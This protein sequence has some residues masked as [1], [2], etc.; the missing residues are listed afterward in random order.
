MRQFSVH[1]L[2]HNKRCDRISALRWVARSCKFQDLLT[3]PVE[4]F[5]NE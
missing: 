5:R 2:L 1:K 4:S 3:D